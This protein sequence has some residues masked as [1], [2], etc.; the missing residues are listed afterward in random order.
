MER[1]IGRTITAL[2]L[3]ATTLGA[4]AHSQDALVNISNLDGIDSADAESPLIGGFSV[5]SEK[6]EKLYHSIKP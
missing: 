2:A 5:A 1:I 4:N 3:A 6:R